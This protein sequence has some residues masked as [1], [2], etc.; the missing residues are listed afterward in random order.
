MKKF[1]VLMGLILISTSAHATSPVKYVKNKKVVN[2]YTTN[3]YSSYE[4]QKNEF[5]A[6]LDAPYLVE[7]HRNWYLGTEGGKDLF[8]TDADEGYFAYGKI[9]YTGTLFS[10]SKNK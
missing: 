7:L 5:G 2:N 8:H 9:T 6:K 1:I 4:E 10:F 3:S